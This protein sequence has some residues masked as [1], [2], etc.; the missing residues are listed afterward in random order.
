MYTKYTRNAHACLFIFLRTRP[1]LASGAKQPARR[2]DGGCGKPAGSTGKTPAAL[3]SIQLRARGVTVARV[4]DE[5]YRANTYK[6]PSAGVSKKP[7]AQKCLPVQS[8]Q[9]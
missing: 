2:L 4:E 8:G 6:A 7:T 1:G 3:A 5:L 9:S